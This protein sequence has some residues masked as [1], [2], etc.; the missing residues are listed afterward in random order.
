MRV[1][2]VNRIT[3]YPKSIVHANERNMLNKKTLQKETASCE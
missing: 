2:E 3:L 1:S